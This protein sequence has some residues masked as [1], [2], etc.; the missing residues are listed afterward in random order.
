MPSVS[1]AP[2]FNKVVA[3]NGNHVMAPDES[4]ASI[5]TM[6]AG[7]L[8]IFLPGPTTPVPVGTPPVALP[9]NGD[10]YAVQDVNGLVSGPN[11]LTVNGGGFP[12]ESSVASGA[13]ITTAAQFAGGEFTFHDKAQKWYFCPCRWVAPG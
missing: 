2:I 9:S 7:G 3:I 10:Y 13:S 12:I 1:Q 8:T 11:P 4:I 5:D 6:P